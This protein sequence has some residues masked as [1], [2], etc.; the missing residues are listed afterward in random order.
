MTA[1]ILVEYKQE[2][3]KHKLPEGVEVSH[4]CICCILLFSSFLK[5]S[6]PAAITFQGKIIIASS[7]SVLFLLTMLTQIHFCTTNNIIR[8]QYFFSRQILT[9]S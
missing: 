7:L 4:C 2:K 1:C 8:N 5:L 3:I 9:E 6:W